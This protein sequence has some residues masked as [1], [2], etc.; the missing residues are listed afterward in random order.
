MHCHEVVRELS[1][2]TANRD[3]AAM[4]KHLAGCSACAEWARRVE[5]IDRLWD[6]TRPAEP[7]PEAWDAVWAN[8]AQAL[9][10]PVAVHQDRED[11]AVP[12]AGP[13][14][15]GTG[16]KVLV[17]SAPAPAAA[18]VGPR[19]RGRSR[20]LAAV[21][22]VALAQAA[23]ILVALGLAWQPT[24][25][26]AG[27][28]EAGTSIAAGSAAPI[29]ATSAVKVDVDV[30]EGHLVVIRAEQT[31]ALMVDAMPPEMNTGSDPGLAIRTPNRRISQLR[32]LARSMAVESGV[33]I[34]TSN[35]RISPFHPEMNTGSDPGLV[36][37]NAME[38][39]ATPQVAAR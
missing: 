35:R 14:R 9:P 39:I 25:R 3:R 11:S 6:A 32:G 18:P 12:D 27:P 1:A 38:S 26:P 13:S 36:I 28:P 2:P 31:K 30:P 24:E 10:C 19:P 37:L 34:R 17:Y 20:R 16:P 33:V 7:A 21:A 4:A 15:N 5:A 23:A 29:R 8:I 22:L